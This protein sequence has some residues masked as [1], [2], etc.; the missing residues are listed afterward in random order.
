MSKSKVCAANERVKHAYLKH[1][2]DARGRSERT[3]DQIAA[4]IDGFEQF[5]NHRDFKHF[6]ADNARDWKAEL[7]EEPSEVTG[8]PLALSAARTRL[9]AVRDFFLWLSREPGYRKLDARDADYFNLSAR[10]ERI[11]RTAQERP[12]PTREEVTRAL[13]EMPHGTL[14]E[15]RNRTLIA[16]TLLTGAR[17]SALRTLKL[18]HLDIA[19]GAVDQDPREVETKGAKHIYTPFF[20]LSSEA[21]EIVTDWIATLRDQLGWTDNDPL[22]PKQKVELGS[23][24]RFQNAGLD[25]A[26]YATGEPVRQVFHD[27]FVDAGLHPYH[28]HTFRHMIATHYAKLGVDAG[29]AKAISQSLGHEHLGTMMQTYVRLSRSDQADLVRNAGRLASDDEITIARALD[30]IQ[31]HL[32]GRGLRPARKSP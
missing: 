3:V 10:D 24:A 1:M 22:F 8:T 7:L 32:P 27:A 14:V 19:K 21:L 29:T 12:A 20:P 30:V 17:I 6:K 25:R 16:F 18:K 31:Q 15:K 23:G 13:A 11:A 26:H 9:R 2:R 28:P 5:T 4:A